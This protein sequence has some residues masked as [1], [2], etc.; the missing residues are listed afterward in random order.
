MD[1]SFTRFTIASLLPRR[2]CTNL[3]TRQTSRRLQSTY[4]RTK[5]RLRVKPDSTFLPSPSEPRDHIIF[6][7]P[8]SIPPVHQTPKLFLPPDD[9]RQHLHVTQNARKIPPEGQSPAVRQPY[10]KRY[11]LKEEDLVEMRRLRK[12]DPITWTVSKLAKKFE[13]SGLFVSLATDGMAREKQLQQSKV[14][15]AVKSRWGAKRR[16][17]RED[18]AIRRE[19]WGRYD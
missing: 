3:N 18:R 13:C 19:T 2:Q 15:A 10:A 14:L 8:S 11:H 16:I 9:P 7:P 6:N 12:E 17:A 5:A 1:K 4:Q